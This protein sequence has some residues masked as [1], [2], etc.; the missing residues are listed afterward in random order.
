[1]T[2]PT[3]DR[4]VRHRMAVLRHAEEGHGER[5]R[6]WP[7][8][9][10]SRSSD[11][12]G[13]R[14]IRSAR[15]VCRERAVRVPGVSTLPR[16]RVARR[17]RGRIAGIARGR[18][19]HCIFAWPRTPGCGPTGHARRGRSR[20]VRQRCRGRRPRLANGVRR[21]LAAAGPAG[22]RQPQR[23]WVQVACRAAAPVARQGCPSR[24]ISRSF[25]PPQ[26]FPATATLRLAPVA[27]R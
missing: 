24:R 27:L 5:G 25:S 23:G 14:L 1:M 7:G 22:S 2:D 10:V 8:R 26:P 3:L 11:R 21:V 15:T 12:T 19:S 9:R 20:T 18:S 17:R 13:G 6:R 16:S 4:Q